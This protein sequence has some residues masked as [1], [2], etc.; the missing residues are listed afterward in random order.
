MILLM[1]YF[2]P[3]NYLRFSEYLY[4]LH[5][6][7]KN[8]LIDKIVLF[9]SDNSELAYTSSKFQIVHLEQRPTYQ[10]FFD[11]CN[12]NF[13]NQI[14]IVSNSD[15]IFDESLQKIKEDYLTSTVY[16]LSRYELQEDYTIQARPEVQ[17][18]TS[19]DAWV[20]KTPFNVKDAN[21]NLGHKT[22]DLKIAYVISSFGYKVKNPC[23]DIIL[24]H[25]HRI[26]YRTYNNNTGY[27]HPLLSTPPTH[28]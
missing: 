9:I 12:Q 25:A 5:E 13:S 23:K 24:K 2:Q 16:A 14:C 3:K 15:I 1:E 6:N 4:A 18:P 28:I 22:C 27:P 8:N 11:Y 21:Y 7:L 10:T 26:N 19:Q 17:L 20:F